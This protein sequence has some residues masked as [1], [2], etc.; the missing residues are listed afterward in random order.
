[1]WAAIPQSFPGAITPSDSSPSLP[2]QHSLRCSPH[3]NRNKFD[4]QRQKVHSAGGGHGRG[5]L[6]RLH[7]AQPRTRLGKTAPPSQQL[8]SEVLEM[9][10]NTGAKGRALIPLFQATPLLPPA[11]LCLSGDPPCPRT[12]VTHACLSAA[13]PSPTSL[14]PSPNPHFP[15]APFLPPPLPTPCPHPHADGGDQ[16]TNEQRKEIDSRIIALEEIGGQAALRP[17]DN[18][19]IYGNY[20]VGYVSMGQ[21]QYGQPAGGRFR[22]GRQG[23]QRMHPCWIRGRGWWWTAGEAIACMDACMRACGGACMPASIP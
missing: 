15:L 13:P 2:A 8:V 4:V 1:M 12:L 17:L 9:I 20:E 7:T 19:L 14:Q 6:L 23:T 3:I 16:V 22:C 21:R 11:L 10:Q 18:E 5:A